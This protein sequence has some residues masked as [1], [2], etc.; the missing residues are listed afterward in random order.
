MAM[1][2]TGVLNNYHMEATQ[3]GIGMLGIHWDCLRESGFHSWFLVLGWGQFR[4][5][6]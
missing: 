4:A 2:V 3:Y 6:V 1:S 5:K